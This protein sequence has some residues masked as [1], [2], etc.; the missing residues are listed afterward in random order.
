MNYL[1]DTHILIW[2]LSSSNQL[3]QKAYKLLDDQKNTFFVSSASAWEITIKKS[4]GKLQ[5]PND[6]IYQMENNNLM[7]LVISLE[8][9]LNVEKLRFHHKDPF[10][11]MLISQAKLENLMILTHDKIFKKYPVKVKLV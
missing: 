7:P 4:I 8:H 5:T 6:L 11:R 2:W 9:S 1:L 10:D 3:P